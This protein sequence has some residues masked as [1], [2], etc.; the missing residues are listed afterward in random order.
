MKKSFCCAEVKRDIQIKR[1]FKT[2]YLAIV[3]KNNLVLDLMFKTVR[4]LESHGSSLSTEG[5]I[6]MPLFLWPQCASMPSNAALNKCGS[7]FPWWSSG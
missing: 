7:G 4:H 5:D 6:F 1:K 2:G 3:L